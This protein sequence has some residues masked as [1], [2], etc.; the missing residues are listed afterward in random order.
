MAPQGG[1]GEAREDRRGHER[2]VH[3]PHRRHRVE[4]HGDGHGAVHALGLLAEHVV[5]VDS[6]D[7]A[8]LADS[9][10]AGAPFLGPV[11]SSAGGLLQLVE[12]KDLIPPEAR[13]LLFQAAPGAAP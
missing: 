10:V 11:A 4:P 13:A 3:T 6:V 1:F 12:L 9:G 5:G 7:E 2:A 8:L